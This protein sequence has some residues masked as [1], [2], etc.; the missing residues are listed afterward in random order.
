MIYDDI[1][2]ANRIITTKAAYTAG[3]GIVDI[4]GKLHLADDD[5]LISRIMERLN[6]VPTIEHKCHNCGGVLEIRADEHL[7]RCPYCNSC[8]AIGINMKNDRG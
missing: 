3:S 6:F 1:V 4:S 2:D 7:F 8:Y 5:D